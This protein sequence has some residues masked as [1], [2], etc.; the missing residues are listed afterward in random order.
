ME[1][2]LDKTDWK[3]LRALQEDAR[4]SY[5]ELGRHVGLS[6]PAVAERVRRLEE[7]GVITGYRATIN[8]AKVG[9]PLMAF[10]RMTCSG[11]LCVRKHVRTEEYPEVLELHRVSG[12]DCSM[13][14][15]VVASVEHLEAL[16]DRLA[17][18]G[19]PAT[20]L[21]LSSPIVQHSIDWERDEG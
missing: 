13:L 1:R 18:Y 17:Q 2:V 4:R 14:K 6:G 16:I 15:V 21:V 8:P 12:G 10:V 3:I 5:N 7:S 20:A 19:Q 11:E 9:L